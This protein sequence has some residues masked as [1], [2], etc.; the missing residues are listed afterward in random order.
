LIEFSSTWSL[1]T[2]LPLLSMTFNERMLYKSLCPHLDLSSSSQMISCS[3]IDQ[4]LQLVEHLKQMKVSSN[5]ESM[6]G[7]F[8][9]DFHSGSIREID[10]FNSIVTT[11]YNNYR[12]VHCPSIQTAKR[13]LCFEDE[14][15]D[16]SPIGGYLQLDRC[17]YPYILSSSDILLNFNDLRKPFASTLD[18][19]MPFFRSQSKLM[20]ENYMKIVEH[21]T[22]FIKKYKYYYK[23]V[24]NQFISLEHLLLLHRSILFVQLFPSDRTSLIHLHENYRN[25]FSNLL[26]KNLSHCRYINDQ[27]CLN[28]WSLYDSI[29]NGDNQSRLATEDEILLIHCLFIYN[30]REI[31][32]HHYQQRP[33]REL[34]LV[35]QS[36][37]LLK[38][39]IKTIQTKHIEKRANFIESLAAF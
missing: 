6:V 32:V 26:T 34:I 5:T 31:Q 23:N 38:E 16:L 25:D 4:F 10:L 11:K 29:M 1:T 28:D 14:N 39:N 9:I 33:N 13:R 35:K 3:L 21:G 27:P 2:K 18:V 22:R 15:L 30:H 37:S 19:L 24:D 12:S 20:M 17:I 36:F 8:Q 7:R